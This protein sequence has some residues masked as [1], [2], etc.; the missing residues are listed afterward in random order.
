LNLARVTKGGEGEGDPKLPKS[1]LKGGGLG[2][3]PGDGGVAG[4]PD[5]LTVKRE[6]NGKVVREG[7]PR[8]PRRRDREIGRMMRNIDNRRKEGV[9]TESD[10]GQKA[11]EARGKREGRSRIRSYMKVGMRVMVDVRNREPGLEMFPT[12]SKSLSGESGI[13]ARGVRPPL[14]EIE[15]P[16]NKSGDIIVDGRERI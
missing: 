9:G 8:G 10:R 1:R 2:K 6:A 5:R 16:T 7:G 14:H 3:P 4:G 11:V 13:S 15:V 12:F